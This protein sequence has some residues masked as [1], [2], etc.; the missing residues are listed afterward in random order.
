[1]GGGLYIGGDAITLIVI[2]LLLIWLL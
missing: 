1:M 2:I